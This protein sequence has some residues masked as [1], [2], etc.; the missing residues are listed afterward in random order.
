MFHIEIWVNE[1]EGWGKM[2]PTGGEPY[3]F[4]TEEKALATA[5][6]CYPDFF[7]SEGIRIKKGDG[8]D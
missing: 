5:N 2:C 7:G 3:K 6:M 8:D 4:E 1:K